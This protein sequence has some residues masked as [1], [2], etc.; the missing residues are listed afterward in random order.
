TVRIK[1]QATSR[2]EFERWYGDALACRLV[3]F[4]FSN[5]KK[6]IL[7]IEELVSERFIPKFGDLNQAQEF[8]VARFLGSRTP[9]ANFSIGN[10]LGVALVGQALK[11]I[12]S[13]SGES[14]SLI[15]ESVKFQFDARQ[16]DDNVT[17]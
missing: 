8:T 10:G 12:E 17:V 7:E 16:R 11:E 9:G 3:L 2:A 1:G 14:A 13:R 6:T 15:V 4:R 5:T